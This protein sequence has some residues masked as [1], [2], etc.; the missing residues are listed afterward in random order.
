M[1]G[2][3]LGAAVDEEGDDDEGDHAQNGPRGTEVGTVETARAVL[4]ARGV[5]D[6]NDREDH[7]RDQH[8]DGEEVFNG[9]E[10][11]S[12]TNKGNGEVTVVEGTVDL[13]NG[14]EQNGEA[15]HGEEVGQARNGPLEELLLTGDFNNFGGDGF[16]GAA[17]TGPWTV[18]VLSGADQLGEPEEPASGD[19]ET[20][21]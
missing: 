12:P 13:E 3:D 20:D 5:L 6:S 4:A 1:T 19:R 16:L 10:P 7:E 15:P 21:E 17:N 11:V 8:H 2:V 9:G 14:G 18:G